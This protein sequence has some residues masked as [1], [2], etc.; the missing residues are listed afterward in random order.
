VL[1][2]ADYAVCYDPK[3]RKKRAEAAL[4]CRGPADVWVDFKEMEIIFSVRFPI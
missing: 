2:G 3:R 4:D 1:H